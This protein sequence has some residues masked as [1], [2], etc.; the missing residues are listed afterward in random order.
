MLALSSHL[1]YDAEE[2]RFEADMGVG[3]EENII[4]VC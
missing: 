4:E 2:W 3:G 1:D